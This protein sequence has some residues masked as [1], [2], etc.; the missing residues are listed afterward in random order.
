MDA[1]SDDEDEELNPLESTPTEIP[2]EH[3]PPDT[4]FARVVA[5]DSCSFALADTGLI[6]GW[7]TFRASGR[8]NP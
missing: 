3:F 4:R 8:M 5:G 7:D 1:D 2:T 6:Y